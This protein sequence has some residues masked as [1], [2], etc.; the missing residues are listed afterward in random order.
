MVAARA[1]LGAVRG[2]QRPGAPSVGERFAALPRMAGATL[3]GRYPGLGRGR[4]LVMLAG[5][6]YLVSP[7]D[8][9]PEALLLVFGL[10]DDALVAAWLAGTVLAETERYL[11]WEGT[12]REGTGRPVVRGEVVIPR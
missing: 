10:A 8:L 4:L 6:L 11:A 3:T 7:V 2:A 1:L 5:V 12:G 9:V